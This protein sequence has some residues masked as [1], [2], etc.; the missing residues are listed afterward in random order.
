MSNLLNATS[1]IWLAPMAGISDKAFRHICIDYGAGMT[2]SEM[3]SAA[4][5]MH[6]SKKTWHYIEPADNEKSF[7]VQLFGHDAHIMLNAALEVQKRLGKRLAG[8]DINMGCPVRKVVNKGEGSALMKTPELASL[9]VQT[10]VQALDVPVSV[11]MRSGWTKEE[12]TAVEF[13][14]A[15]QEAGAAFVAVHGRSARQ[16]YKGSANW[17]TIAKVASALDIA[18]IGSGDVF[19]FADAQNML[20]QTGCAAVMAARGARGNPWIFSDVPPSANDKPHAANNGEHHAPN[21]DKP[22][23]SNNTS[24]PAATN[25]DE[26]PTSSNLP[27][28]EERI[29]CALHYLD[30]Y[31]Y[32]YGEDY[33]TPMRAKLAPFIHGMPQAASARRLL[34]TAKTRQDFE[35]TLNFLR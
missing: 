14:L 23:T 1:P 18:V 9:L 31:C 26:P 6:A 32:Y 34:S 27:S 24:S 19:S 25:P 29:D 2:Y 12:E 16:F 5:L 7:I 4:G 8:I 3:V 20:K 10:L 33:L 35:A 28:N 30:L 21:V 13:G 11:K 22:P 15:M 17:E